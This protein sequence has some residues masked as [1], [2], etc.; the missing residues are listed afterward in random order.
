MSNQKER[1]LCKANGEIVPF[2]AEKLRRSL[3]NAG[4]SETAAEE[5]LDE[6][7][8][9]F[10][11]GAPSKQVYKR[12]FALLKQTDRPVAARYQLKSAI[13]A[14]GP[15]GYPFEK[16]FAELLKHQAYSVRVGEVVEGRCVSHEIDVIAESDG[17]LILVECKYHNQPGK[18]SD[19]KIPLYVRSRF[20]DVEEG[21]SANNLKKDKLIK[22]WVATNTRFTE[23]AL[24]Y[25]LCQGMRM[26]S[27]DQP[28]QG[29]LKQQVDNLGLYPITCLTTLTATEKKCLLDKNVV[30][31]QALCAQPSL[32]E[33]IGIS[34]ARREK[35]MDESRLLCTRLATE[36][37]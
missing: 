17:E 32:L 14:L 19:V 4:A 8:R 22:G 12:A 28:H 13:M 37:K 21:M 11:N 24:R 35:V 34:P 3:Q 2:S 36:Q 16:F 25:G 27:W 15:S 26:V 29:S 7:L 30:L 10:K 18:V 31:C 33:Q 6:I 1:F 5:V 9:N 23:D 20:I